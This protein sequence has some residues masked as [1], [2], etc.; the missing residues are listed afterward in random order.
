MTVAVG[1]RKMFRKDRGFTAIELVI[2]I[3]II[4][5]LAAALL[6]VLSKAREMAKKTCALEEIHQLEVALRMYGEDWGRYPDDDEFLTGNPIDGCENLIDALE[7]EVENGPYGT[8]E[9][10]ATSGNFLDPWGN[11]Y[12]YRYNTLPVIGHDTGVMYNIWS[13]G[14][15]IN[16]DD[17]D[18]ANW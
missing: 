9:E 3:G 8:W 12:R 4:F 6:P 13:L 16:N 11:A 10:D 1:K 14:P 18:I 2:V 7:Y 15:D 5:I 17:D